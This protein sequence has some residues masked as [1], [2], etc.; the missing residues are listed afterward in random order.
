MGQTLNLSSTEIKEGTLDLERPAN[1]LPR[2]VLRSNAYIL[3]DGEWK[4]AMD[5]ED[6]GLQKRWHEK[7][8]YLH[9][10]RWPG[11]VE[12]HMAEAKGETLSAGWRDEI[13]VWYE[14]TF[15]LPQR[16]D[17]KHLMYQLT[18][19]ACGYDTR[20]W[21]NGHPLKTIEGEEVHYGEYTSFS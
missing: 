4:F 17:E 11:S 12:S 10:A 14:R 3:L 16:A 5:P 15:E 13:V 20:V 19:G 21:L 18:F 1:V 9:A 8:E 6:E 7:H 2:T